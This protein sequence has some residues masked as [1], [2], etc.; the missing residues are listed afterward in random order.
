MLMDDFYLKL[1]SSYHTDDWL[2]LF[3][4]GHVPKNELENILTVLVTKDRY[5]YY[6]MTYEVSHAGIE[7]GGVSL[8]KINN[9][10]YYASNYPISIGTNMIHLHNCIHRCEYTYQYKYIH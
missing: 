10:N 5:E 2:D 3:T 1:I 7:I 6:A 9:Y 8:N 4:M